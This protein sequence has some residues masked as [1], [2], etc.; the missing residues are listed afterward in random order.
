[1]D[2]YLDK[3]IRV[4]KIK[5]NNSLLDHLHVHSEYLS[6]K[7]YPNL[8]G[9]IQELKV[10]NRKVIDGI[11]DDQKGLDDYAATYKSSILF[12]FPNRIEDGTYHYK[13]KQY[14]FQVNEAPVNNAIHGI[15]YDKAFDTGHIHMDQEAVSIELTYVSD[16]SE[17]GFPFPFVL[18]L[19]YLIQ[20]S[21]SMKL[22]FEVQNTGAS[23]F[24]YGLGWHPY[25]FTESLKDCTL[26]FPSADH[27]L[28]NERSLPV[29]E[30]KSPLPGQFEIG[31]KKFDDAYS[32]RKSTCSLE[33]G[34]YELTMNFT[35]ESRTFL[36]VYTPPHGK[37]IALEPMTCIANSFNSG[38]GM[39][40]LLPGNKSSWTVD[41]DLKLKD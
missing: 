17:T 3:K 40:E 9:S 33:T 14:T 15:V 13:G 27:F 4:D 18:T 16:G 23:A 36:Q 32:L 21:G 11:T 25:F 5:N 12:P 24:P 38:I 1:M 35:D 8:G 31:E 20:V 6:V 29:K 7:I 28:C 19:T 2:L 22:R 34:S 41:L 37:S 26:A 30:V 39:K 10:G